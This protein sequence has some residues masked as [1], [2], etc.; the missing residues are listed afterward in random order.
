MCEWIRSSLFYSWCSIA[1][2]TDLVK[3]TISDEILENKAN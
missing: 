1:D 3:R 2:T